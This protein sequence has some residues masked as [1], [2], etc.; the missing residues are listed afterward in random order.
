MFYP[1]LHLK[2]WL[3]PL[4]LFPSTACFSPSSPLLQSNICFL[5]L[6]APILFR[7]YSN[8]VHRISNRPKMNFWRRLTSLQPMRSRST[9]S[10]PSNY[11]SRSAPNT[12]SV[13]MTAG[14]APDSTAARGPEP[15]I[16][17]HSGLSVSRES[18]S[19]HQ[20]RACKTVKCQPRRMFEF[21]YL[22]PHWLAFCKCQIAQQRQNQVFA[23]NKNEKNK[24]K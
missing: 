14:S 16:P 7:V 21:V 12:P 23:E 10:T 17:L 11:R 2:M 18:T 3:Y 15:G 8:L 5:Y 19:P 6:P 22:L 20:L 4:T 24:T 13:A 9:H 1:H